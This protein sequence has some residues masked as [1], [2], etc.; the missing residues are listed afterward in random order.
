MTITYAI[1]VC[2]EFMEIQRLINFLLKE[3]RQEDDIVILYDSAHG[4]PEIEAY[5]RTHSQ[6]NEFH[7]HKGEFNHHFADWKN[8]LSSYCTGDYI[9]QIDA[10]EVPNNILIKELPNILEQYSHADVFLMSRV[11]ILTEEAEYSPIEKIK[12]D[13][14]DNRDRWRHWPD[15]QWRIW[16]NKPEIHWINKIHEVLQ[17]YNQ[18]MYLSADNSDLSLFHIKTWEKQEKQNNYYKDFE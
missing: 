4:D 3:K 15:Y 2:N 12:Q 14:G 8:K 11:N 16:K 13:W 10:D 17:G 5:L 18:S 6:N 7:W 9:F 1:T